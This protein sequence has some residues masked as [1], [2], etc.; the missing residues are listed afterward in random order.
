MKYLIMDR[1]PIFKPMRRLLEMTN[2]KAIVLPTKSPNLNAY[3]ERFH[4]SLKSECLSWLFLT[5]V[6]QLRHAVKEYLLYYNH[7]RPHQSLAGLPPEPDLRILEAR[8]GKRSGKLKTQERLNGL[9][10]FHYKDV[11]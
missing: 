7:E 4:L 9:L 10:K 8:Q 6:K 1:D 5:S 3:I 2:I 11:A